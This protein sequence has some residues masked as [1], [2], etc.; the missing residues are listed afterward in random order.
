MIVPSGLKDSLQPLQNGLGGAASGLDALVGLFQWE[1]FTTTCG[2]CGGLVALI[3]ACVFVPLRWVVL[4]AGVALIAL[5]VNGSRLR[6]PGGLMMVF[7]VGSLLFA[8]ATGPF[9]A[10]LWLLSGI[11]RYMGRARPPKVAVKPTKAKAKLA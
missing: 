1:S 2:V 5:P 10:L 8:A 7:H 11:A 6:L 4:I 3:L 9:A